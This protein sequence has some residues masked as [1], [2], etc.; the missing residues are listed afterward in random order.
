MLNKLFSAKNQP[1]PTPPPGPDRQAALACIPL[2]NPECKQNEQNEGTLLRYKIQAK[3]WLRKIFKTATSREPELVIRKLQLDSM[4]S[5]VWK[6]IDGSK[7]VQQISRDFQKR[8]NLGQREAEISVSEFILQLGRR[9]LVALK[10]P[11]GR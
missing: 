2:R 11:E 8:H 1:K 7:S 6:M 4:G 10:E 3:P 5:S 9:G